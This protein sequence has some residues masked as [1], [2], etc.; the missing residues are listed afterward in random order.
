MVSSDCRSAVCDELT[1]I[2]QVPTCE[3]GVQNGEEPSPDCGGLGTACPDSC[4]LGEACEV[5][6]NCLGDNICVDNVCV[7]P[8]CEDA[9]VNY[10]ETDLNCGGPE[11]PACAD[12]LGC[13]LSTDI[14]FDG[15]GPWYGNPESSPTVFEANT[16]KLSN[17]PYS[18]V[19]CSHKP[20]MD[21]K[22][23]IN[24]FKIY[25]QKFETQR[26]NVL[27]LCHQPS[28][29][30]SLVDKSPFYKNR[31]P[32]KRIQLIFERLMILK[33]IEPLVAEGI[34]KVEDGKYRQPR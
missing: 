29:L 23:A 30:D 16:V 26:Q 24:A 20:P 34:I 13:L 17:L 7:P 25:I 5:D 9:Y 32:D 3:D 15:F 19:C 18:S 28:S 12:G 1:L 11:C 2:C 8:G 27:D 33:I 21:K 10:G 4:E 6:V 22:T 14:D 31:L